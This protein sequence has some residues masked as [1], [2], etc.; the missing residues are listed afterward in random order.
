[1]ETFGQ[2]ISQYMTRT[3]VSDAELA[4]GIGVSRQTIF[5]WKEGETARPR[6]RDDVLQCAKK[7][8]LTTSERD[9][10]L[11]AAGFSPEAPVVP[12]APVQE[13]HK[14][15]S[16]PS[17]EL[18]NSEAVVMKR[19]FPVPAA[20]WR[21]VMAIIA[22]IILGALVGWGIV[23]WR[24]R[25]RQSHAIAPAAPDETLVIVSQFANYAGNVGYNVA[26]RVREAIEGE[27][28]REELIDS[29]VAVWIQP[30]SSRA[31]A[32]KLGSDYNAALVI[33]GEY[34]SGRVL[35]N[36]TLTQETETQQLESMMRQV[37]TSADLS[38]I[39]NT[40]LPETARWIAL[41]SV[42]Q[43]HY[44][45]RR[46]E[47]ALAAFERALSHPPGEKTALASVYFALGYIYGQQGS[48]EQAID[49]YTRAIERNP[50]L[51]SAYNNRGAVYLALGEDDNL[52]R[53]IADFGQA[54]ELAPTLTAAYFN[55]GLAYF[56]L[57]AAYDEKSLADLRYAQELEPNALGANNALCW[58]LSLM[59]K[60][61]DALPYC[62]RAVEHDPTALSR[63]SRGLTYALLG[64]AKDAAR[65]FEIFLEWAEKQSGADW[66]YYIQSRRAWIEELREGN[67]PFSAE[68]LRSLRGE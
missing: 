14:P 68:V 31:E 44:A 52:R 29:R 33:W 38:A 7:L 57:G 32:I 6:H 60:P 66:A 51:V 4:R 19:V 53:A 21:L 49:Y 45:A 43:V 10:L 37:A 39:I 64:R 25:Q 23:E 9:E 61:E 58:E 22:L 2:L 17:A 24:E 55:R 48:A 54:I 27:F 46:Y 1:M 8:R 11:L 40:E 20:R 18:P 56:A 59:G 15:T 5:R 47:R 67:N 3:G 26:G 12:P 13:V 16:K 36:F 34:D 28:V 62:D 42:G 63:D 65:D 30:L 50:A 41:V 35:A